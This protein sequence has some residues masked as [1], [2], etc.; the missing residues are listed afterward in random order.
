MPENPHIMMPDEAIPL[1]PF[2]YTPIPYTCGPRFIQAMKDRAQ[3][4]FDSQNKDI[5]GGYG[6]MRTC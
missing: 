5:D 3:K 4:M 2:N 6:F 1:I